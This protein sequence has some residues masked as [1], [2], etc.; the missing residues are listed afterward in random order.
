MT[1]YAKERGI[2]QTALIAFDSKQLSTII[3]KMLEDLGFNCLQASSFEEISEILEQRSP[4][5]LFLDWTLKGQNTA[6]FLSELHKKPI[7]I[8][9]SKEKN[10]SE[11]QKALDL[12]VNEYIMKP[13]DNDI[14][15]SKLSLAGLL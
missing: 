11:I 7:L 10:P 6:D 13:F 4:A 5:V 2:M 8:F 15:Q 3:G 12:G 14:L 9:I 1:Y